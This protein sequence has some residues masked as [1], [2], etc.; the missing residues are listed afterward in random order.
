MATNKHSILAYLSITSSFVLLILGS[1]GS[2]TPFKIYGLLLGIVAAE[3]ILLV[4][5]PFVTSKYFKF[6]NL[7]SA[8][9]NCVLILIIPFSIYLEIFN[10][11][12]IMFASIWWIM[13]YL[14]FR[15]YKFD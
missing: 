15:R 14:Q 11:V 2:L 3:S 5:L 10:W 8:F 12:I 7:K 4:S 9:L 6:V 13:G 1:L